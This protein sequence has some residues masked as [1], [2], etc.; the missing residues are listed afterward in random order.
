MALLKNVLAGRAAQEAEKFLTEQ[1]LLSNTETS[2]FYQHSFTP[3]SKM[4]HHAIYN[5]NN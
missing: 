3:K 4:R 1:A 5:E 2:M